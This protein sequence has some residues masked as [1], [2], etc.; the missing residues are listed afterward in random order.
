MRTFRVLSLSFAAGVIAIFTAAL[1][2]PAAAGPFTGMANTQAMHKDG[3]IRH[4]V[5][6]RKK[7]RKHRRYRRSA[8]RGHRR[9]R[10]HYRRR[11]VVRA[12]YTYV[13]SG[14]R[15]IV[16]APFAS[17][18]VGRGVH[19]RAPFVNLWVPRRRRHYGYRYW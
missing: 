18:Y 12:P 4:A 7:Y 17:V 11:N 8:R 6:Y 15:V 5:H 10:R 9:Y 1:A 3:K 13:E 16:D 2:K 14:R 19:V